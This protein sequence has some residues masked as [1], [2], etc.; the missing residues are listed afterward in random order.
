MISVGAQYIPQAKIISLFCMVPLVMLYAFISNYCSRYVLL[1]FYT[2]MYG[3]FS[4]VIAY[5]ILDPVIGLSNIVS[6]EWRLFGWFSYLFLEGASPFLVG[7]SWSFLS[8]I[9]HPQDVKG[10][11]IGMTIMS[12]IGGA[13]FSFVA[14]KFPLLLSYYNYSYTEPLFYSVMMAISGI[15]CLC[16]TGI[17]V[18]FY[19]VIPSSTFSGFNS[20]HKSDISV[21]KEDTFG[22]FSLFKNSY[23]LGILGIVFFWEVINVIFNNLR[24]NVAFEASSSIVQISSYLFESTFYMHIIGLFF[25]F[26]GTSFLVR[27]LGERRS[28]ILIPILIGSIT[29]IFF[30]IKNVFL[31]KIIYP[32]IGAINYS[33]SRPLRESL[34]IITSR[35]IQFSTKQW[36]DSFGQ[37]FSKAFGSCYIIAIQ[38]IPGRFLFSFQVSFFTFLLIIWLYVSIFLGKRWEK[39]IA[40][41]EIIS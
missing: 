36:I 29:F 19:Y 2:L 40:N 31:I 1:L 32:V 5:F 41:K 33:L 24:L 38:A 39:A 25:A 28:L 17:V 27:I 26:F 6:S 14:W 37:K 35:K 22:I 15:G 34:F 21:N 9:S 4:L 11:Y 12:K 20:R 3:T 10:T 23:I 16:L 18:L 7:L 13:L 8:S 30:V